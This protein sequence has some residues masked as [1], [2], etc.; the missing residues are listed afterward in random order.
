MHKT[1]I[2][3]IPFVSVNG[4]TFG[5][6]REDVW[7]AFGAPEESFFKGDDDIQTDVYSC[8]H[9]CYDSE[10]RFEA[11]EVIYVDEADIY[12]GGVKVPETYDEALEFFSG[13]YDDTKEDGA[14]FM[15]VSG[16]MGVYVDEADEYDTIL[17]ARKGYY[18]DPDI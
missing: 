15:T 5:T 6:L 2:E 11:I 18:G 1:R 4:V 7:K 10:Y 13:L 9:V 14:G 17:F 16:A 8:F 3:V 12:Y